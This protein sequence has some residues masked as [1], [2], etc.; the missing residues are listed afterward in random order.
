MR[1][2]LLAK[3]SAAARYLIAGD[4][5]V[6][7]NAWKASGSGMLSRFSLLGPDAIVENAELP[8]TDKDTYA[9]CFNTFWAFES[10][11]SS[12]ERESAKKASRNRP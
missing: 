12:S 10:G 7:R 2:R 4:H 1:K 11:P 6:A 9:K 3:V 8:R 5:P